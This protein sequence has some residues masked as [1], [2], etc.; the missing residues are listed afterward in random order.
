MS[1]G[2]AE[3]SRPI[4]E[5]ARQICTAIGDRSCI[6]RALRVQ[7][8]L[9]FATAGPSVAL[10]EYRAALPIARELGSSGEIVN[11]LRGE[12]WALANMDD[13]DGANAALVE[14]MLTCQKAGLALVPGRLNLARLAVMQG[15]L[16]R[17][18]ALA[19]EAA[20]EARKAG[21][22]NT[23]TDAK[24]VRAEALMLAGDQAG[25]E[26]S[27]DE[28]KPSVN[29]RKL[30]NAT[31]F[32]WLLSSASVNRAGGRM[33]LAANRLAEAQAVAEPGAE[34]EFGEEQVEQL[35]GRHRYR[36][37]Q[38]AAIRVREQIS[39]S[40][41]ASQ[42]AHIAALLSD[43]YGFD[44]DRKAAQETVR[45]AMA[46]ISPRSMPLARI[47]VL[48]SAGR[49]TDRAI[50]AEQY[51]HAA[52]DLAQRTGFRP[53][54]YRARLVLR[55]RGGINGQAASAKLVSSPMAR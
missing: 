35:I 41:R 2:R 6:L 31:L 12:G 1:T 4:R 54:E 32:N 39:Q 21:D 49:W 24:T 7:A 17:A 14:V 53:A 27:L 40:G 25:A 15:Q 28:S 10:A 22:W 47:A 55:R 33:D 37:A 5:E 23:E 38:Q 3:Q 16:A 9:D 8:N 50:E 46:M 44:G 51:L 42:S 11:L 45:S 48:T 36:D 43:A 52:I 30:P 29:R 19:E 20:E 13:F 18:A 34:A 26:L